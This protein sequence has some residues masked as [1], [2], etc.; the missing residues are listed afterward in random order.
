[1]V[2]IDAARLAGRFL[3]RQT[4]ANS[5]RDPQPV[6]RDA[7]LTRER[8]TDCQEAFAIAKALLYFFTSRRMGQSGI[9]PFWPRERRATINDNVA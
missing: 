9:F 7:A 5:F 6:S 1:M 8:V 2:D 3:V 4:L